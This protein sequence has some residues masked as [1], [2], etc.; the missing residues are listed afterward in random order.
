MREIPRYQELMMTRDGRI[1]DTAKERWINIHY[2]HNNSHK[3]P[4]AYYQV[5][6]RSI[7]LNVLRLMYETYITEGELKNDCVIEFKDGI[8]MCPENLKKISK[9]KKSEVSEAKRDR[10]ERY[11]CWMGGDSIYI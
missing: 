8:T 1:W 7:T 11:S 5:D 10:A 6:G 3:G 4:V 2:N 9:W